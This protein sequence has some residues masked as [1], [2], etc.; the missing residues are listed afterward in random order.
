MISGKFRQLDHW[1]ADSNRTRMQLDIHTKDPDLGWI[2]AIGPRYASNLLHRSP[3]HR[4]R[5][6]ARL[7]E[8]IRCSSAGPRGTPVDW[9]GTK[10]VKE[11]YGAAEVRNPSFLPRENPEVMYFALGPISSPLFHSLFDQPTDTAI[12]F[13]SITLLL[14]QISGNIQICFISYC[15]FGATP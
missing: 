1:T 7:L 12:S 11:A 10:E 6:R 3:R 14:S 13:P 8:T 9:V 2:I 15:Q 4:H 5:R